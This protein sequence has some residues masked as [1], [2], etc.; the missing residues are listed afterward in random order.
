MPGLFAGAQ[1]SLQTQ[2][3]SRAADDEDIC[4][5]PALGL[6]AGG[7]MISFRDI[8]A[9]VL[10]GAANPSW[11]G[12]LASSVARGFVVWVYIAL[13]AGHAD[14]KPGTTLFSGFGT[15]FS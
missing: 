8:V 12:V 14:Y 5:R 15:P 4:E 13:T 6:M 1:L 9:G 11:L 10:I 3:S 7:A 2:P